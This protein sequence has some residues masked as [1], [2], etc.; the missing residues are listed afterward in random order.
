MTVYDL[1]LDF[2]LASMLILIGQ[3]LRSKITIFQRFFMPASMIAGFLGLIL[4]PSVLNILPFSESIASY[5]GVLIILIFTIVGVNGFEFGK[6]GSTKEDVNRL[7]GFQMYRFIAFFM[8][9]II[10]IALTLLIFTKVFPVLKDGFGILLVS[11]FYGGHGTAV[12]VGETLANLGW[13]DAPDLAMT[14]ATM[15]ILTGVFGGLALIKIG[16]KRGDSGYIKD[17]KYIKGDIKTGLVEKENRKSVGEET[18]SPVS[19]DTV[20]FHLS[21]ILAISGISYMLNMWIAENFIKGIPDFTIAYVLALIFFLV[22][23]KT[24]VYNYIDTGISGKI[25]GTS[26]DYLVFFGIA[27]IKLAVVV[28]YALPLILMGLVG[29]VM[30]ALIVYPLG[31]IFNKDSWFERAMFIFG[32]STGVFAIGFVLLR[33]VDPE[34]KSK[35]IEDTAMTPLTSFVEILMWSIVPAILMNGQGWII[36]GVLS[37]LV[38]AS[39]I[40]AKVTGSWWLGIDDSQRKT[41]GGSTIKSN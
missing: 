18:I 10:P 30:V 12:A 38:V 23:K 36:V 9:F 1:F 32:Y 28:K 8:Q 24:P 20:C 40:I 5:A 26:T 34:N 33:I 25:S 31:K 29:I 41:L 19:L 4:G 37:V 6:K 14:F 22:F 16:T 35:T 17:F 11:G 39:F 27:S 2:A 21:I 15:G 3:L 13:A 7:I